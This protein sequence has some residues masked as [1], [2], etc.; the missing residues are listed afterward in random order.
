MKRILFIGALALIAA[1]GFLF[2]KGL[3]SIGE[4]KEGRMA[5]KMA[6][7]RF[8]Q[9]A[10]QAF[11]AD[12][13]KD[14]GQIEYPASLQDLVDADYLHQTDLTKAQRWVTIEYSPPSSGS[15]ADTIVMKTEYDG[16]LLSV[17]IDG[18]VI[19]K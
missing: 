5:T 15:S 8:L 13:K 3:T 7:L 17:P 16:K 6:D 18:D 10:I 12:K 11:A 19:K 4:Y 2:V 14:N 9:L 1:A